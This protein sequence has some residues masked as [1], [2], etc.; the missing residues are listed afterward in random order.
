VS[1]ARHADARL[2]IYSPPP[3]CFSSGDLRTP[4]LPIPYFPRRKG[5]AFWLYS[6]Q[7]S[8]STHE[9]LKYVMRKAPREVT[10]EFNTN[11]LAD[12]GRLL[13]EL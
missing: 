3:Y 2:T 4:C 5:S 1:L 11:P 9:D 8:G 10:H 7:W 13:R 6:W 12:R